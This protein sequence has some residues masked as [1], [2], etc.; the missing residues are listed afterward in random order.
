MIMALQLQWN[1]MLS[2]LQNNRFTFNE[3]SDLKTGN[4]VGAWGQTLIID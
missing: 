2:L 3:S 4:V 1:A